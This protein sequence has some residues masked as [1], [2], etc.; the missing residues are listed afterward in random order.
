MMYTV[1]THLVETLS[2]LS[3]S[4]FLHKHFFDPLGMNSTNLDPSRARAK[5]LGDRISPGYLWDD[6]AK[7]YTAFPFP[8]CPEAQGAGG[9]V[10]SAN[11]Y[12]KYITAIMNQEPPFKKT[13]YDGLIRTRSFEDADYTQLWALTSS[14]LYGAAWE[15]FFYHGYMVV[16]HT[17]SNPGARIAHFFVP[18]IKFGGVIM[19]NSAGGGTV[20]DILQSELI[21]AA[22]KTPNDER[23][24][25]V[26]LLGDKAAAQNDGG[27]DGKAL[28]EQLC[29]GNNSLPEPQTRPLASYTGS[30]WNK[31]YH[32]VDV[33]I[34]DDKLHING[35]DRSMAFQ[36]QFEHVCNQTQYIAH[37]APEQENGDTLIPAEFEFDGDQA[38][39]LG[40]GLEDAID[41]LIW[42]DK[43]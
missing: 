32:Y 21:D 34:E 25:W 28:R 37:L 20:R 35:S 2:D 4:D 16:S 5:G 13:V 40:L 9:I 24:K 6:D 27:D 12:I 7:N 31:G 23:P 11:D 15:I 36:I 1:A 30:Y 26:T 17:G 38:V 19:T 8:D 10:T 43:E 18:S 39:G 3:F 29:A 22:L 41:D 14:Y 33:T 42:F